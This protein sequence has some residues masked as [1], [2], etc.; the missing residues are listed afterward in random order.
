MYAFAYHRPGSVADAAKLATADS[1]A[2][3]LAGGHTLLPTMKLRLAQPSALI[4]LNRVP[5]LSGIQETA[6]SL[7]IGATTRHAEVAANA[8]IKVAL[9]GF[10]ALAHG[11]GDP[12]VRQKGTIGGSIANNDPAADYPAGVLALGATIETTGRK[13]SADTF[14]QGMFT[15]ALEEGELITKVHIPKGASFSYHKF[16]N[17]ASLFAMVGV[18]VAKR[19]AQVRVAVTGAGAGGVFR[20][21]A[22]EAALSKAFTLASVKSAALPDPA[23]LNADI[24]ASA[25]YRSHLIGVMTARAVADLG[26]T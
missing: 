15:T 24:H 22:A 3:F 19:G 4:D 16:R 25:E 7:V 18:A 8:A 17:P 14:F 13:I 1:D 5:G 23:H 12:H 2:K 6:D 26:G 20:W 9:P 11:I 10:A 21:E